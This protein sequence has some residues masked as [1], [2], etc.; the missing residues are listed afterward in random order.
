MS[1]N[2]PPAVQRPQ[3]KNNTEAG[4]PEMAIASESTTMS[5]QWRIALS[6]F[7]GLFVAFL[8]LFWETIGTMIAIWSSRTYSHG[9]LIFPVAAFLNMELPRHVAT[10]R[11]SSRACWPR[12]ACRLSLRLASGK[13][14]GY[15]VGP[16]L[17][18]HCHDPMFG[19]RHFWLVSRQANLVSSVFSLFC[20]TFRKFC[21]C[22]SSR[23]YRLPLCCFFAPYWDPG[24]LG[25]VVY[26]HPDG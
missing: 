7:F 17:C 11:T 19:S 6:V 21:D 3:C 26:L 5:M 16:A 10:N 12:P 18:A 23:C 1:Y 25:R 24:L 13:C 9:F 4:V 14:N 2:G 8:V 20:R 15:P 22:S